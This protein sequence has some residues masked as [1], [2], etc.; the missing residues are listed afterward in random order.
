MSITLRQLTYFIAAANTGQASKA[1][2]RCNVSQSSMTIALKNLES[3]VGTRLFTRHAKGL[4]LTG[5]GER[6]LRHAQQITAAVGAAV[7][8]VQAPPEGLRGSVRI[9]VT[10]TISTY[11]I[12]AAIAALSRRFPNFTIGIVERDRASIEQDLMSGHLELALMLVSNLTMVRELSY[13]TMLCSPRRLWT[14]A[15]HPL[16]TR[17]QVTLQDVAQENYLLLDMDDHLETVGKY[18]GK[19]GLEP[20]VRFQSK[21]IEAIRSLVALGHG[22]TILSDLVYRPW[23]LDGNRILR[24]EIDDLVPTMDVGAV[25]SREKVLSLQSELM[26]GFLRSS[27]QAFLQY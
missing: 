26:L 17:P 8:D 1:A 20:Q 24:R 14:H 5:A 16:R 19:F 22:V 10:E 15:D 25:W 2:V 6:F 21:S 27:I 11:L 9:G 23:S 12:P 3:S 13:E 4:R 18:W 7:D